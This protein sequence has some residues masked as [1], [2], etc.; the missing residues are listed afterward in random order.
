MEHLQQ[1][2]FDE[3]LLSLREIVRLLLLSGLFTMACLMAFPSNAPTRRVLLLVGVLALT[4]LPWALWGMN[5]I[6]YVATDHLPA[7]TL[8]RIYICESAGKVMMLTP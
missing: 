3:G 8:F 1:H 5:A 7:L 4:V 2:L 6:W